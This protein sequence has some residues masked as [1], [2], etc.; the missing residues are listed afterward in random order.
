MTRN[1][2]RFRTR[3]EAFSRHVFC[4]RRGVYKRYSD[5]EEKNHEGTI[6]VALENRTSQIPSIAYLIGGV[7]ALALSTGLM[8]CGRRRAS[9]VVG[10]L[11]SPLLIMGLYNKMVKTQG[12]DSFDR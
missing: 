9:I 8:L 12:H 11:A 7:G 10:Q 1:D 5:M 4:D 6:T 2:E 3:E